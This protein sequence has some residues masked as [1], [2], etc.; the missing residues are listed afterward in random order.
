MGSIVYSIEVMV[1]TDVTGKIEDIGEFVVSVDVRMML[2]RQEDT[3]EELVLS[4]EN[5]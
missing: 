3:F 2:L 1:I 5:R 4:S